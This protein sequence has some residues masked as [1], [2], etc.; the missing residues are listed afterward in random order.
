[1]KPTNAAG[2]PA[3]FL[4]PGVM[5][6]RGDLSADKSI[7]VRD[8][9]TSAA[10]GT[11]AATTLPHPTAHQDVVLAHAGATGG[12]KGS[13]STGSAAS[14]LLASANP[15]EPELVWIVDLGKDRPFSPTEPISHSS[16]CTAPDGTVFIGTH[17]GLCAVKDGR[18]LWEFPTDRAVG[19]T[20]CLGPDGTVYF[21]CDNE[22]V[23]AVRD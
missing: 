12:G 17:K 10:P 9:Y 5:K 20:P 22:K 23:Y 15:S 3:L 4:N 8:L 18:I 1:M 16:P 2:N 7:E 14:A 19:S 6:D 13:V 11:D 21:G